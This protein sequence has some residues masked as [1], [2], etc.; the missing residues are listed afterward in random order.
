MK[1]H[2][3]YCTGVV[4]LSLSGVLL[5]EPKEEILELE[6]QVV[7]SSPLAPVAGEATQAWSVL[8]GRSLEEIRGATIGETLA[9]QP[10][11]SQT[12]FG[13]GASRP[14]IR[15]LEGNRVLVLQNGLE[16][17]DVSAQSADHAVAI[18]PLLVERVEVLRGPAALLYGSNAIGGVVN[19]MDATIPTQGLGERSVAGRARTGY[20][21][22]N[23]GKN[24]GAVLTAGD[25]QMVV[26]GYGIYRR[27][28]DYRTPKFSLKESHGHSHDEHDHEHHDD[29]GHDEHAEHHDDHEEEHHAE[30]YKRVHNSHSRVW[31]AGAG[32]TWFLKNGY[33]GAG[34]SYY[35]SRYGVPS[36]EQSTIEMERKRFEVKGSLTPDG[37]NWLTGLRFSGAY[38]DYRHDELDDLG[39]LGGRF[40]REGGEVRIE[41]LHTL[42]KLEGVLGVQ[43]QLEQFKIRGNESLFSGQETGRVI[44]TDDRFGL[45]LFLLETYQLDESLTWNGGVRGDFSWSHYSG[46]VSSDSDAAF[47][48][49]TGLHYKLEHGWALSGNLAYSQRAADRFERYADGFHHASGIYEVG[50]PGLGNEKS[51]GV[52]I[53]L[54]KESGAVTGRLTGYYNRFSNFIYLSD[55]GH[56]VEIEHAH[57]DHFHHD[58]V[59]RYDYRGVKAEFYG[60]EGELVWRAY[61]QNR[62]TLDLKLFGDYVH[63][64]NLTDKQ[65]LPRTAPWRIGG[66]LEAGIDDLRVGTN[67]VYA[68]KQ[69]QTAHGETA[70]PDYLLLNLYASYQLQTKGADWTLFVKGNNLTNELARVHTS[71]LKDRAP[72]SGIGIEFGIS[73]EF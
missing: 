47:S 11:I 36:E 40:L 26:R 44:R 16:M 62:Y 7:Q 21:S 17:F 23:D 56:H 46:N 20:S 9:N 25:D 61:E 64:R 10:G 29:H 60:L 52:E 65:Y 48:A 22:V 8:E 69:T 19:L 28:G 55:S 2:L 12:H 38:A 5:A 41:A 45:G 3:I 31:Q 39:G 14:I 59:E 43:A 72:L 32:A 53:S 6:P 67:L 54:L 49:S 63:A 37:P 30:T 4:G 13:S 18:D 66:G 35:D 1:K 15:G 34:F 70:T 51:Y 68:G 58:E 27:S 24:V 73:A 42:G 50:N 33:I 71:F 57:G